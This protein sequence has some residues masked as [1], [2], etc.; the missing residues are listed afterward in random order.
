[1]ERCLAWR[2]VLAAR[3]RPRDGAGLPGIPG[4]G[5][6]QVGAA[7]EK[8]VPYRTQLL[9]GVGPC[10]ASEGTYIK[11]LGCSQ[12]RSLIFYLA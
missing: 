4:V 9:V 8:P 6:W 3:L 1:M 7:E 2:E 10:G 5:G 11:V 12:Q